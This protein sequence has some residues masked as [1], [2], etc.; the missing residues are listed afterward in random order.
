MNIKIIIRRWDIIRLA[1]SVYLFSAVSSFFLRLAISKYI[2][3]NLYPV[4]YEFVNINFI[5]FL[6][7]I[8]YILIGGLFCIIIFYYAYYNSKKY[9]FSEQG[10][11]KS[12]ENKTT[13]IDWC[14]ISLVRKIWFFGNLMLIKK[15]NELLPMIIPYNKY[16]KNEI[17]ILI[18][19]FNENIGVNKI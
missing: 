11:E 10:I 15:K 18:S 12:G 2:I 9:V 1:L 19:Y 7:I 13:F 16:F 6:K 17:G 3:Q 4:K 14:Q 5:A 8:L